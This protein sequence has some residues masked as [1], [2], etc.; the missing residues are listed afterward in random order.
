MSVWF[1]YTLATL[2]FLSNLVGFAINFAALPGNLLILG[3]TALFCWQVQTTE[4][5]ISWIT[6]IF[7]GVLLLVGEAIEFFAGTAG[8]AKHK[9]SR[10]ALVLSVI[11]SIAGSIC[12]AMVGVPL[13]VVGSAVGAFLG[14]ALGAAGGAAIGEDWK[15][16][17]LDAS[18]RVG[19]AAFWGRILG[20]AGKLAIG[21]VMLVIATV[22]SI[23]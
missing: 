17:R 20:T 11:G 4:L 21:A 22:D 13:P 10:R 18:L 19:A 5:E 6:V 1:Y 7:L 3:G 12:G 16:R 8:A 15:G 2:L 14:G 9:A 23:W